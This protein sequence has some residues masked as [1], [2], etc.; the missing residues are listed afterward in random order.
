MKKTCFS[1]RFVVA[2]FAMLGACVVVRAA[3]FTTAVQQGSTSPTSNWFTNNTGAGIWLPGNVLPTAG[4]T[5]EV[6]AG[7]N[8]S[9]VRNPTYGG[10][11]LTFPG[12]SLQ[13]NTNTEIRGKTATT[14]TTINFPGV[15]GNP[16]LILN[17]GN[18]DMGDNAVMTLSGIILVQNPS[19]FTC[20]DNGGNNTRGWKIAGELRGAT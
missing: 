11:T 19:S 15:G 16:G 7:G 2:L 13:L 20:G 6:T 5:Y 18:L 12:D 9:R 14:P 10:S 8:P 4:N 17:G 1:L 3:N